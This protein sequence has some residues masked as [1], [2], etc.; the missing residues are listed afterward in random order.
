MMVV[1]F[2]ME[3]LMQNPQVHSID[4]AVT[5]CQSFVIENT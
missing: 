5:L 3:E 1:L 2:S 4:R